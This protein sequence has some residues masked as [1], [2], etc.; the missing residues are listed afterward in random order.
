MI[1]WRFRLA[2]IQWNNKSYVGVRLVNGICMGREICLLR[3]F[4]VPRGPL[5]KCLHHT[6]LKQLQPP[7]LWPPPHIVSDD[8]SPRQQ[9]LQLGSPN[10]LPPPCQFSCPSYSS[11]NFHLSPSSS[12]TQPHKPLF[13]AVQ[14]RSIL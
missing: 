8:T 6:P 2:S 1:I 13:I 12:I 3:Q 7:Q 5:Q 14:T 11:S 4:V 9:K 10:N